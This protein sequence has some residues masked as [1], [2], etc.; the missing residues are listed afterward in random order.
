MMN[1]IFDINFIHTYLL[2]TKTF[3]VTVLHIHRI[4]IAESVDRITCEI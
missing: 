1:V 3:F 2:I 4:I